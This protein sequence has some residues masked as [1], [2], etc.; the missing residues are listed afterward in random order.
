MK[1]FI[2]FYAILLI[3][4][5]VKADD[6]PCIVEGKKHDISINSPV[7]IYYTGTEHFRNERYD[8]AMNKWEK[9]F[10][11]KPFPVEHEH[12]L[13][14]ASNNLGYLNYHGLGKHRS[15]QKALEYWERAV[16][17]G[18]EES[19]YHLCYALGDPE[20]PVYSKLESIDHCKKAFEFYNAIEDK[21]ENDLLILNVI[22]QYL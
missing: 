19:E 5:S 13:I 1:Q 11:I 14:N 16:M 2:T 3:F 8:Q 6:V 22:M 20:S 12:L 21:S 7:C 10:I 9:L 15:A 17:F 4:Q 18:N